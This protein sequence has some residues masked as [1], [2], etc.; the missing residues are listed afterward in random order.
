MQKKKESIRGNEY[1][2]SYVCLDRNKLLCDLNVQWKLTHA[3]QVYTL[4]I[5]NVYTKKKKK[6]ILHKLFLKINFKIN[7]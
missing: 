6:G 1:F 4:K 7:K 5:C 2:N 3:S